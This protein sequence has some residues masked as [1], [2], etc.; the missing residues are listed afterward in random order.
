M[1]RDRATEGFTLRQEG[2]V[3]RQRQGIGSPSARRAMYLFVSE[4]LEQ[5]FGLVSNIERLQQRQVFIPEAPLRVVLLLVANVPNHRVQ[6]RMR[7]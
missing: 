1:A 3:Y 4:E 2:H 7:V 5:V 6:V